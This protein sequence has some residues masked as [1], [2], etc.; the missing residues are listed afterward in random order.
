MVTSFCC[1]GMGVGFYNCCWVVVVFVGF[2]VGR[3]KIGLVEG[4]VFG[5]VVLLW[6]SRLVNVEV[7]F[8]REDCLELRFLNVWS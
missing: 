4:F 2:C 6:V 3:E 8:E 5:G 7:W 1:V